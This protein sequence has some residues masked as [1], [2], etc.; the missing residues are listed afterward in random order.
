M[1]ASIGYNYKSFLNAAYLQSRYGDVDFD[2]SL[3][4][5]E[6][7]KGTQYEQYYNDFKDAKNINHLND[8]KAQVD[9]MQR[10]RQILANSSLF[11]QFTVGLF[12]PLNL[13]ALPFG[14][15][16]YGVLRSAGRVGLGVAAI[17]VPL[18]VGRQMFDPSATVMESAIN[19]GAGFF[20]GATLGGLSSVA[21]NVRV[22]A[23]FKTQEEISEMARVT[24]AVDAEQMALVGQRSQRI[25]TPEFFSL[26]MDELSDADVNKLSTRNGAIDYL[27]SRKKKDGSPLYTEADLRGRLTKDNLSA[28]NK[29]FACLLYTSP[30]PRD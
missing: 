23:I 11:A 16:A 13:I 15:P 9:A 17:Q 30:S 8:L 22:N 19:L 21:G 14:G 6:E 26:R 2:D 3:N 29:Y 24:N 7:I 18:E 1:H 27:R 25:T 12:D 20:V 4:V 10:R 28:M 5:M